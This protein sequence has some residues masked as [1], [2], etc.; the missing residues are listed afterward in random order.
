M[1]PKKCYDQEMPKS[2]TTDQSMAH[3]GRVM[4]NREPHD[5]KDTINLGN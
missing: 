5:S 2:L 3:Q 1:S 4:E